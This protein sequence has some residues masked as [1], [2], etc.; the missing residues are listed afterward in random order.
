M[1]KR[2]AL[3][4]AIA[5]TAAGP[6]R[7][8]DAQPY[9]Q[10]T[11]FKPIEEVRG[12]VYG[13]DAVGREAHAAMVTFEA[14]SSPIT[15]Y[16]TSNGWLAPIFSPRLEA[17][18]MINTLGLTSYAFAGLAWRAPLWGPLFLEIG[19][20]GAVNDSSR[21]RH[22]LRQTDLGCPV[23]FRE[24][25]GVGWRFDE[26]FDIVVGIEHISHAN[27]CSSLNP[28]LTSAGVRVGYRF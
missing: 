12:G 23:T 28:G 8:E 2:I 22:N 6:A 24:S 11:P 3:L 27:L 14:Q 10:L 18:A 20:G 13:D 25:G 21:D 17:G 15:L 5:A 19:L 16:P 26:H 9:G 1:F 4:A 7:A